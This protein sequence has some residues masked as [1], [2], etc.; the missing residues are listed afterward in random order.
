MLWGGSVAGWLVQ[1]IPVVLLLPSLRRHSRRSLQWL[2]FITLFFLVLGILQIFTPDARYQW[3]G[4]CNVVGSLSVFGLAVVT[5][6]QTRSS[7][8]ANSGVAP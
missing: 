4:L 5:A 6:R 8:S 7:S 2:G 3:L 1:S